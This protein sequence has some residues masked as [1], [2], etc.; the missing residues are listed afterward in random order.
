[1]LLT[2]ASWPQAAMPFGGYK[3]SGIGRDK[4]EEALSNFTQTKVC[5]LLLCS[6]WRCMHFATPA[7]HV[8]RVAPTV[9]SRS[10]TLKLV[11]CVC[12]LSH[13]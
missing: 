12:W 6:L 4:G 2:S 8:A 1:M 11:P 10:V 5:N 3:N 7:Q 13:R 9:T